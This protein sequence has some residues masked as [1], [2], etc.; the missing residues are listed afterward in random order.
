M[1]DKE[2]LYQEVLEVVSS[3]IAN[4]KKCTEASPTTVCRYTT[5]EIRIS[6]EEPKDI[7]PETFRTEVINPVLAKFKELG[8]EAVT[9]TGSRNQLYIVLR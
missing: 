8:W 9:N 2:Q 3:A 1:I 5:F 7:E 4:S 6:I